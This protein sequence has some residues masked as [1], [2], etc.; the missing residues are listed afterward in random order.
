MSEFFNSQSLE[1]LRICRHQ[2]EQRADSQSIADSNHGMKPQMP[3]D[4]FAP[5][6]F[7]KPSKCHHKKE[8][9]WSLGYSPVSEQCVSKTETKQTAKWKTL[10]NYEAWSSLSI[11]YTCLGFFKCLYFSRLIWAKSLLWRRANARNASQQTL[12]GVQRIHI[13]LT[14]IHSSF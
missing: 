10:V 1:I 14:L 9:K 12:Y 13:N 7:C 4:Q 6:S 2:A 8:L 11:A 3:S 5:S